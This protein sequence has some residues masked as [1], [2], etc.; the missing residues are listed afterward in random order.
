MSSI[1]ILEM[2]VEL[3]HIYQRDTYN[4]YFSA[5]VVFDF[6]RFD[7]IG[8]TFSDHLVKL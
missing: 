3:I 2:S 7:G 5:K 6:A 4:C 1:R 8:R